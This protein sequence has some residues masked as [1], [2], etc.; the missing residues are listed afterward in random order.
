[1]GFTE[2]TKRFYDD[3]LIPMLLRA[4]FEV[5]DPWAQI[6]PLQGPSIAHAEDNTRLLERAHGVLAILDGTDV[7]SGTA[8]EIG[9]AAARGIPIVGVRTDLRRSGEADSVTVNLQVEYFI[10]K[11]GGSVVRE[12]GTAIDL[13][14]KLVGV[15]V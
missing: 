10:R 4:G 12:F 7:D 15:G 6:T 3:H 2:P 14:W 8:S 13:L 5:L 1:L 11:D 9:F